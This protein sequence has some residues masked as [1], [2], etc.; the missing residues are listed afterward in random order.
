MKI[1]FATSIML[2]AITAFAACN[3]NTNESINIHNENYQTETIDQQPDTPNDFFPEDLLIQ[4]DMATDELLS[5]FTN[6]H[7][8]QVEEIGIPLVIWANQP[9]HDVFIIGFTSEWIE[10]RYDWEF[11]PTERFGS[12]DILQPGEAV[13]VEN[14]MGAGTL[15]K[16]G[17]SFFDTDSQVRRVFVFRQNQAYPEHGGMWT[18]SNIGSYRIV[19]EDGSRLQN[20]VFVNGRLIYEGSIYTIQGE[21][22]PTHV[23]MNILHHL[24]ISVL[25]GGS[26]F[27]LEYHGRMID[28]DSLFIVNYLTFGEDRVPIGINDFF[29]ADDGYF[30]LYMPISIIEELAF[31]F[32]FGSAFNFVVRLEWDRVHISG[33]LP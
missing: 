20:I 13:V 29:M 28:Y 16:R 18:I 24:G 2:L 8:I 12:I 14:Y 27:A 33:M 26:Q 11:T 22:Y 32:G 5:L 19:W 15:P 9:L 25:Q 23:S 7:T 10:G 3:N 1:I 4:I 31:G 21:V 30:T 6:L 17:I